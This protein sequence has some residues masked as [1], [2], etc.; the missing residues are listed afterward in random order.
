MSDST[1]MSAVAEAS[2]LLRS[3]DRDRPLGTLVMTQSD[4]PRAELLKASMHVLFA[5]EPPAPTDQRLRPQA[6]AR[7]TDMLLDAIALRS[8]REL[9]Y[10]ADPQFQDLIKMDARLLMIAER[11]RQLRGAIDQIGQADQAPWVQIC[12]ALDGLGATSTS[13]LEGDGPAGTARLPGSP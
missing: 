12:Q 6:A 7:I 10:L 13:A 1:L 9:N 5:D 4:P 8:M 11:A 2:T 3:I